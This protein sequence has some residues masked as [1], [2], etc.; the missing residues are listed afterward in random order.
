MIISASGRTDIPAYYA[1][2]FFNRVKDG[3]VCVRN[4]YYPAQVQGYRLDPSVVDAVVFCTKNPRPMLERLR[5]ILHLRPFFF[6]TITPYGRDIEPNVPDCYEVAASLAELST[7][8]G[9]QS[10][11]WRYDPIF[12]NDEYPVSRH[13]EIFAELCARLDGSVSSCVIS[14][15]Q[16]Y[17]QTPRNFPDAGEP[18]PS[19]R[20]TMLE[21]LVPIGLAHGIVIRTCAD[22]AGTRIAGLDESG[23]VTRAILRGYTGLETPPLPGGPKRAGCRCDLPTR[24]IGAYNTCPH[25]C[26][27]CYANHDLKKVMENYRKHDPS[28]P[29]LIGALS[30]ADRIVWAKQESFGRKQ[31]S[32]DLFDT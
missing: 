12:S 26:K 22:Y 4:P 11:C 18:S 17:A 21:A 28:S 27:Y 31:L 19:E 5:E 32:L 6:V 24:D 20:R 14:F 25:G 30:G 10:V 29:L 13:V 15:L 8:L 9:S 7:H 3:T 16:S 1:E 23:C 2:W